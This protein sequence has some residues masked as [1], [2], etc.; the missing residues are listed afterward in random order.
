MDK[1]YDMVLLAIGIKLARLRKDLGI[2]HYE[3]FAYTYEIGRAQYGRYEKGANITINT[4]NQLLKIHQLTYTEFFN[5]DFEEIIRELSQ[6]S[7][8]PKSN[9]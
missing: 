7:Q 4:F 2:S 8:E 5:D 3:Q 6:E 9:I 1:Y